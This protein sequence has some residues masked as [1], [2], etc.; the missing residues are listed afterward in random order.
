VV[1]RLLGFSSVIMTGPSMTVESCLI[2]AHL[3]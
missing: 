2:L 1:S 3:D